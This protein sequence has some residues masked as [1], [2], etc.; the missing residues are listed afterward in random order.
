MARPETQ[1]HNE[2]VKALSNLC[3]AIGL[4]FFGYGVLKPMTSDP[5]VFGHREYIFMVFGA[6][7]YGLGVWQLFRLKGEDE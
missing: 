2:R 5:S 4:G 1:I 3:Y 6:W 7:F